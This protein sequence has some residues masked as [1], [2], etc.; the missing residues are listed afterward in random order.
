MHPSAT[1]SEAEL[2]VGIERAASG[3]LADAAGRS[4]SLLCAKHGAG[5]FQTPDFTDAHRGDCR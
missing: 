3:G 1:S 4:Q 5:H 2:T